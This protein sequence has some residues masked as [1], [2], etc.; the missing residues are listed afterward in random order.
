VERLRR[1]NAIPTSLARSSGSGAFSRPAVFGLFLTSSTGVFLGPSCADP[2]GLLGDGAHA[3]GDGSP[4]SSNQNR[5]ELNSIQLGHRYFWQ[6]LWPLRS[7][8]VSLPLSGSPE[9]DG[10]LLFF[11]ASLNDGAISLGPHRARD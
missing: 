3:V 9:I 5:D 7:N 10:S 11:R 2:F 6:L 4:D 8:P 1:L